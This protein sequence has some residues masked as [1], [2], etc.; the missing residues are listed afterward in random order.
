MTV[1]SPCCLVSSWWQDRGTWE[2]VRWERWNTG[3]CGFWCHG[4]WRANALSSAPLLGTSQTGHRYSQEW[5]CSCTKKDINKE[6]HN[7]V[8]ACVNT[9][10]A[11]PW[12]TH[13]LV[14]ILILSPSNWSFFFNVPCCWRAQMSVEIA[15]VL[16]VI[17]IFPFIS[18]TRNRPELS[19]PNCGIVVAEVQH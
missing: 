16:V 9:K 10:C 7:Y 8:S 17:P 11:L 6:H 13:Q 1:R 3:R 12:W 15:L 19:V 5:V 18:H 2:S 4:S 14:S